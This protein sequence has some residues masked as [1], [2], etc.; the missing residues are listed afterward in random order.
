MS[1]LRKFQVPKD[2]L[3]FSNEEVEYWHDS[4]NH[5]LARALWEGRI[6]YERP[7]ADDDESTMRRPSTIPR[8]RRMTGPK[9]ARMMLRPAAGDARALDA[10]E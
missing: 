9:C 8:D 7:A 1:A 2:I 10:I 5:V 3:V 6:L 4:L